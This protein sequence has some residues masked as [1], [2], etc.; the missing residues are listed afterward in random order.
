MELKLNKK[1]A[2][3]PF[4]DLEGGSTWCMLST[5]KQNRKITLARETS[6]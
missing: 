4:N 1:R 3:G 6:F 5:V 2:A